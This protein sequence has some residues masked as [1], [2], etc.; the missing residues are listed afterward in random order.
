MTSESKLLRKVK[1]SFRKIQ[2][3]RKETSV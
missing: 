2:D 1:V 3:L